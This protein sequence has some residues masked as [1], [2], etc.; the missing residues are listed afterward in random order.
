MAY[1]NRKKLTEFPA[2]TPLIS[3]SV[4][5]IVANTVKLVTN[6]DIINLTND[7]LLQA[8]ESYKSVAKIATQNETNAGTLD[9][10]IV[11]PLKLQNK[12]FNSSNTAIGTNTATLNTINGSIT[13][14][15]PFLNDLPKA[16]T[17][18]NSNIDNNSI[19]LWSVSYNPLGDEQVYPLNYSPSVGN[20]TFNLGIVGG[21]VSES[22][23]KINFTILNP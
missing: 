10:A 13:Y 1:P 23:I 9:T 12:I 19:I 6:Q 18:I 22:A 20:V 4:V 16:Y 5:G 3:D 11:T 17:L 15:T 8:T 21:I 14:G 2:A 7:N